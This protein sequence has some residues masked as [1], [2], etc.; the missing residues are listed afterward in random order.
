MN[1]EI[2]DNANIISK[3]QKQKLRRR[4]VDDVGILTRKDEL[5]DSIVYH[6]NDKPYNNFKY[7]Q[8]KENNIRIEF[9]FELKNDLKKKYHDKMK[10]IKN[11]HKRDWQLYDRLKKM[12]PVDGLPT[13]DFVRKNKDDFYKFLNNSNNKNPVKEYI[14]ACLD[15]S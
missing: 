11:K 5:M 6:N 14:Q 3:T 10:Y 7:T 13:P 15:S 8:E 1:I 12:T 2:L 4:I 9:Y